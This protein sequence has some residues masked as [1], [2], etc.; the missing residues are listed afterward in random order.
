MISPAI[1][2]RPV[3]VI[4]SQATL[5]IGSFARMAS[6]TASEIW[7]QILSGCPSVTDSE[8]K[9]FFIINVTPFNYKKY[10]PF[11]NWHKKKPSKAYSR[12]LICRN[13]P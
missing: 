9:N 11:R 7:S 2:I 5:A 13:K 12:E 8:V 3:D 6:R 1:I 10:L 4:V